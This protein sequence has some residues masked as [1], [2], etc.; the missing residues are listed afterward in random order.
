MNKSLKRLDEQCKDL[1]AQSEAQRM[2]LRQITASWR[3]PL[4]RVDQGLGVLRYLKSHPALI[5]GAGVLLAAWRPGKIMKWLRVSRWSWK[6]VNKLRSRNFN[7][8][9]DIT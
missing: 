5:I 8:S 4:S 9:R 3:V 1:V 7:T 6:I 2:A